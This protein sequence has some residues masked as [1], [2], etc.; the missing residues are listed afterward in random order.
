[1]KKVIVIVSVGLMSA[2]A[3]TSNA[4]ASVSGVSGT[5]LSALDVVMHSGRKAGVKGV[6]RPR[7]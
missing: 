4:N 5:A 2:L 6:P 7:R 1:M 3:F